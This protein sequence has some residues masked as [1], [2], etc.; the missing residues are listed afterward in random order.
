MIHV[1]PKIV[2]WL[3]VIGGA[4]LIFGPQSFDSSGGRN[5]LQNESSQ[6]FLPPAKSDRLMSYERRLEAGQLLRDEFAEYQTLA[7]EHQSSFWKGD[8]LS[9]EEALSEFKNNRSEQL[10]SILAERG[11]SK[12]EQSIFF[13]VLQRDHPELLEDRD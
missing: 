4:Y 9:V 7:K 6:L 3:L 12:E 1:I 5:P 2:V 10:A 13:T 11:L 8:G